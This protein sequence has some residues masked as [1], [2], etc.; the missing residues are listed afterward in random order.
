MFLA[1]SGCGGKSRKTVV[2]VVASGCSRHE[3][4]PT[5]VVLIDRRH[6]NW[7][8]VKL[9]LHAINVSATYFCIPPPYLWSCDSVA[10]GVC[11]PVQFNV[12]FLLVCEG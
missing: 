10:I 7:S 11:M 8:S 3:T 5:V 2:V 6:G 9:I 12:Y 4:E 1:Y